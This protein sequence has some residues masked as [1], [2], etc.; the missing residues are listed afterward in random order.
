MNICVFFHFQL[1]A[2]VLSVFWNHVVCSGNSSS[3]N[4]IHTKTIY[5]P[6][7]DAIAAI[8]ESNIMYGSNTDYALKFK[9]VS[10]SDSMS[11]EPF[12]VPNEK[13]ENCLVF[14]S[15]QPKSAKEIIHDKLSNVSTAEEA[16]NEIKKPEK[17]D[18][19]ITFPSH[20]DVSVAEIEKFLSNFE[21]KNKS[22]IKLAP[23]NSSMKIIPDNFKSLKVYTSLNTSDPNFWKNL[24]KS[25]ANNANTQNFINDQEAKQYF[26][27]EIFKQLS[28]VPT[29]N[30]V[31][32]SSLITATFAFRIDNFKIVDKID[33]NSKDTKFINS[34][35]E[36]TEKNKV[37]LPFFDISNSAIA[38]DYFLA[39]TKQNQE[40]NWW[41][42]LQ[43]TISNLG[44]LL[45]NHSMAKI[46]AKYEKQ[47]SLT[48]FN[49]MMNPKFSK[50]KL[51]VTDDDFKYKS[52]ITIF[53]LPYH[54]QCTGVDNF[55][56]YLKYLVS[57]GL[58]D[59]HA[60][61]QK[62]AFED[63]LW[64]IDKKENKD[65]FKQQL[66]KVAPQ[67]DY[68]SETNQSVDSSNKTQKDQK[69]H[70]V[71]NANGLGNDS[72][73]TSGNMNKKT[74]ANNDGNGNVI[75]IV[76]IV[77][78]IVGGSTGGVVYFFYFYQK[79]S[80]KYQRY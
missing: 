26:L 48:E 38:E 33:S 49:Q 57:N 40:N 64:A 37:F 76:F 47:I 73:N 17:I 35:E 58:L 75:I 4:K 42:C 78:I 41:N 54:Q 32:F 44:D 20:K 12:T 6:K 11:C 36:I 67:L 52:E 74:A 19:P 45:K 68:N 46:K 80:K 62:T 1:L 71:V 29:A 53:D 16:L 70:T 21:Y 23:P 30:S 60:R 2:V 5:I 9:T 13:G 50:K 34:D 27:G 22:F 18:D 8:N 61:D 65:K 39:I 66:I 14:Y 69:E 7:E 3:N 43:Q 51:Q 63:L 10:G 15:K 79:P 59:I 24:I 25:S 72:N 55:K 77:L 28:D 56:V 31:S